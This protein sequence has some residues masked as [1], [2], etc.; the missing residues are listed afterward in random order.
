MN[1]A[2]VSP[3][4]LQEKRNVAP[5]AVATPSSLI[6]RPSEGLTP[7]FKMLFPFFVC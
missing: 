6:E 2:G 7:P 4:L 3:Y 1:F 5:K